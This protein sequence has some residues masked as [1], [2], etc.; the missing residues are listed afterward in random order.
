MGR[1]VSKIANKNADI[2]YAM[3]LRKSKLLFGLQIDVSMKFLSKRGADFLVKF[4][5]CAGRK[6]CLAIDKKEEG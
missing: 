6:C 5:L 4:T 1:G 3:P 2:L